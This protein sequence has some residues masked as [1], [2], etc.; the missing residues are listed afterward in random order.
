MM[1][2][3]SRFDLAL[4]LACAVPLGFMF[5]G[6]GGIVANALVDGVKILWKS[7]APTAEDFTAERQA[8]AMLYRET[9]AQ[10]QLLAYADDF[11]LLVAMFAAVPLFLPLMRRVR[12][13]VATAAPV[14]PREI[15]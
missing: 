6:S 8:V 10:A 1:L 7:N 5:V 12:M 13:P 3:F 2:R 4:A 11:W 15:E 14:E 9:V